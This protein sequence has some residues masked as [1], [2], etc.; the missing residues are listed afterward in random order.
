MILKN[1]F[2]NIIDKYYLNSL[3]ESVKWEIEDNILVIKFT[4]P[5]RTM[6]GKV[7]H[8]N[9]DVLENSIIGINNTTQLLKL[10]NITLG[11]LDLQLEKNKN[12]F[13]KLNIS[14]K[15][16]KLIYTL[17]DIIIIPKSGEYVGDNNYDVRVTLD[18]NDITALTKA[19]SALSESNTVCLTT[20]VDD[21]DQ[22]KIEMIFGGD[23][24][25]SNKI[26]Y[27]LSDVEFNNNKE[28]E[29]LFDSNIIKEILACNKNAQ[30][31]LM[32]IN[33]EG[34]IRFYFE[35]NDLQSEYYLVA[36]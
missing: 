21:T 10:V 9:F 25:Y 18:T 27:Y 14:D 17:A 36:K 2:Q 1:D 31:C 7:T 4:S 33:V 16:Y 8:K 22:R 15:N 30:T 13:T 19:K 32:E 28:F 6:M 34:I 23:I 12:T 26:S 24:E 35:D 11:Y 29:M 3:I 20:M 5:D